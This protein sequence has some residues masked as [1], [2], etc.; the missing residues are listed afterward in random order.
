MSDMNGKTVL[1]TGATAGI[2]K[3]T[4]LGIAK[5]GAH[6]VIIGRNE[7]KT[8][9]VVDELKAASGNQKIDFL[10]ADLSK[11]ADVRKVAAEFIARFGTLNVLVNNAGAMNLTREVTADGFELT[12][13]MNHLSYFL[14]TNLLVPAL[15]KGAPSRIVSVASDAHLMASID[16]DDLQAEKSYSSFGAYGRSK[17]MNIL[18]TRELAKH[19]EGKKITANSLHPGFVASNFMNKPGFFGRLANAFQSLGGMTVQKGA[20]T[21]IYLATSPEVEGVTG[22]YFAKRKEK[23]PS[24]AAQDDA[25]AKRLWDVSEKLVSPAGA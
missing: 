5:L 22:K 1:V 6:L 2:G 10:L 18:W 17:L 25:T 21:S 3:E 20:L 8:R 14:L 11:M 13:G 15:E 24:K 12:F 7:A 19:L 9:G 16:F 4:A 23:L